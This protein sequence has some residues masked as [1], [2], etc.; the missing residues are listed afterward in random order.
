VFGNEI[1][2]ASTKDSKGKALM[3]KVDSIKKKEINLVF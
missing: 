3:N 2:R 1:L